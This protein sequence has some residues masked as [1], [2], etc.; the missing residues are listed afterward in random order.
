MPQ[1]NKCPNIPKISGKKILSYWWKQSLRGMTSQLWHYLSV[2]NVL[3]LRNQRPLDPK[4]HKQEEAHPYFTVSGR[5]HPKASLKSGPQFIEKK[6]ILN[7]KNALLTQH[8]W[9]IVPLSLLKTTFASFS[10]SISS[11]PPP[12]WPFPIPVRK[13]TF[14]TRISW[15]H[16]LVQ[17][18]DLLICL[19]FLQMISLKYEV[20]VK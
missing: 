14:W 11:I 18:L 6:N 20:E 9:L 1:N 13:F 7:A 4:R 2:S 3:C 16:N 12:T 19:T 8:H 17:E 15:V 5:T 10:T